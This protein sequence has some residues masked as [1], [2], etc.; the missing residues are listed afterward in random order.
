MPLQRMF[1]PAVADLQQRER[2]PD[3]A[4]DYFAIN[5]LNTGVAMKKWWCYE[6]PASRRLAS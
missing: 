3:W 2:M 4:T 1:D 6:R 5:D